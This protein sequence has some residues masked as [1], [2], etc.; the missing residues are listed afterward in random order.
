[1]PF[2]F[3]IENCTISFLLFSSSGPLQAH[4]A[5]NSAYYFSLIK[6]QIISAAVVVKITV[7]SMTLVD[8]EKNLR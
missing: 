2:Y 7:R 4:S 6:D 1:M 8:E 3:H 5:L